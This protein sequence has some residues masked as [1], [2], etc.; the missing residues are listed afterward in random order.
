MA[1]E[2]RL[3]EPRGQS[4]GAG[5]EWIGAGWRL[6]ARAPLMWIIAMLVVFVISIVVCFIPFLGQL[7]IQIAQPVFIA[8]FMVACRS[9]ETGGEFELEHVF[10]GFRRNFANLA[11]LGLIF[12]AAFIALLLVFA[13]FA[14]F[15]LVT[16]F[17]AGD[18]DNLVPALMA[19]GMSI[20]MGTMVMLALMVPV[21]MA[22]W[23]APAL[24]ML[25]GVTPVDAM[26]AS[27]RGCLRNIV[28]FIVYGFVMFV[29][30]VVAM[31]PFGLGM[32]VWL[33]L[34][35]A[36]TYAAYRRIFTEDA[37]PSEPAMAQAA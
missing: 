27:F 30:C 14:G 21:L 13:A 18:K 3:T 32:L 33:P 9:L 17:M 8:G 35:M 24:V 19:S 37:L 31:I 36:S 34:A 5:V 22:Y 11:V 1:D 29:L 23:F 16:A 7:A 6:F 12:L 20:F 4:A 10:A 28:P 26:K 2:L 15:G 25:N